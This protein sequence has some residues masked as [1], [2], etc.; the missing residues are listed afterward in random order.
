M[1][2]LPV[3]FRKRVLYPLELE[4]LIIV[5]NHC[6]CWAL[7]PDALQAISPACIFF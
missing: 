3:D 4:L 6:E 7:K 1:Y 2:L 5:S